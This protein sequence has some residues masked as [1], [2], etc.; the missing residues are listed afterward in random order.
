[1]CVLLQ[2]K[3]LLLIFRFNEFKTLKFNEI[4]KIDFKTA[5]AGLTPNEIKDMIEEHIESEKIK[6]DETQEQ[7]IARWLKNP[8]YH[9][10]HKVSYP[11]K[12]LNYTYKDK[13]G[14]TRKIINKFRNENWIKISKSANF[15]APVNS[16]EI[17]NS[18]IN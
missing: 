5:S 18:S 11:K 2:N 12:A 16:I 8:E 10:Y 3:I 14:K 7:K 15:L 13:Y 1:M 9:F 6:A 4:I 17:I